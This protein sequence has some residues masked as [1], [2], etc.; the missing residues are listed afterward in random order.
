MRPDTWYAATAPQPDRPAVSGVVE[1][2]TAIVGGGLAGLST[3]LHLARAGQRVAVIE[4]QSV[5]YGASGRNGGIVSPAFACG[6]AAIAARV[7]DKAAR[8]LHRLTIEGVETLRSTIADLGIAAAS[9]VSGL[10]NLRRYDRGDDLAAWRDDF[11][12]DYGYEMQVLTRAEI[13]DRLAT[14]RYLHGVRDPHALHIHPL[15]YLL[16]VAAE[17]ERLGGLIFEH[18]PVTAHDLG[19]VKR[20]MTAGGQVQAARVVFAMGGYTTEL[21]PALRRAVLPIATYMMETEAAPDALQ[22]AIRTNDAVLD[23]RRSSD[24]YRL[25]DGGQRLLWGGRISTA[26]AAPQRIALSLRAAMQ[27]VYPQLAGVKVARAWSGWMG[28]A[29]HLMPQIGRLGPDAWHITAF[30]GHGLNTTAI[31]AKVL[32]EAITGQSRRIDMFAPWGLDW[33]GGPFGLMAAQL[34]YWGLQLQDRWREPP[35]VGR[36]APR[37]SLLRRRHRRPDRLLKARPGDRPGQPRHHDPFG[38]NHKGFRH[39]VDAPVD[40][41]PPRHIRPDLGI[42]IAHLGQEPLRICRLVLVIH[43]DDRHPLGLQLFQHRMLGPAR[44]TPACPEVH[45]LDPRSGQIRRR[46]QWQIAHGH[47]R[48]LGRS[49]PH[50]GRRQRLIAVLHSQIEHR[51]QSGKDQRRQQHQRLHASRPSA[52]AST[53]SRRRFIRPACQTDQ[54]TSPR[55]STVDAP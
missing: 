23:D 38:V 21:V 36:G 24:Y 29:R 11:A 44:L 47:H 45:Q 34:T 22:A 49:P 1:V 10:M 25:V 27:D 13:T 8:D 7:G 5:G 40:P 39:P 42:G 20:L 3:A 2:E 32:A 19:P 28:Y 18:S 41:H 6:E 31:G 12:R 16:G 35:P 43:P 14:K 30:G 55:I 17:I 48:H 26:D 50:H 52:R 54:T 15:S 33:A 4:A 51:G 53:S 37:L 9:P 46:R